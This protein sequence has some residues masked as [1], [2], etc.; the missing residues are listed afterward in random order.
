MKKI[1]FTGGGTVGHVTL[2]LLLIP[3]FLKDGWE[4]HYIGDRQGIEY[5]QLV[6]SGLDVQFHGIAT[7]KLRRY[8]SWQNLLDIFKVAWGIA[9]SLAI[10]LAIRPQALFSKGGFVSV[11]PVIAS[12]LLGIPVF[13]HE[14][15]LSMGLA[16]KIAY[17][18]ATTMYSTFEQSAALDKV[19]HVGA[20]TKVAPVNNITPIQLPEIISQFDENVPTLLFVG[21][22]GG[23]KI[24]NDL[25]SQH[26]ATLI[27]RFNII[28]LTGDTSLNQLSR[29][30]YRV[31]Y[32]TDLYQPLM[33][34]ADVVITRGGSN[35]IFEL[36][37]MQKLHLIVPLGR[38]ASRGDQLE[39]ARYF[40]EKGYAK[41]LDESMLTLENLLEAVEQLLEEKES[42]IERMRHSTEIQ[43]IDHFYQLLKADID[44]KA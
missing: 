26:Q 24:F 12:R 42:Y 21:G 25:I 16:N 22:S 19:K 37:A 23:A 13:V 34:E 7:G 36:V 8:F 6:Q 14:S 3:R 9:Q 30:L 18:F 38:Q 35:T 31:D 28:N 32:V 11:P 10:L 29:R 43:T 41:Q 39:N 33:N 44:R 40:E 15:D 2:N 1:V 27:E 20:V 17:K 5:Q 4:V